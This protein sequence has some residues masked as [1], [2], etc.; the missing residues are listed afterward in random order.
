MLLIQR[1]TV[2]TVLGDLPGLFA[3]PF[4]FSMMLSTG[5]N[6]KALSG[7]DKPIPIALM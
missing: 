2:E 3:F 4:L 5:K 1:V 6:S 7:M